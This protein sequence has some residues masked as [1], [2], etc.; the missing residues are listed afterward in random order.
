VQ[1]MATPPT[2]TP[3]PIGSIWTPEDLEDGALLCSKGFSIEQ[4]ERMILMRRRID[5]G[6]VNE[7]GVDVNHVE[8]M[9]WLVQH[10]KVSD[11]EV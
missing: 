6:E 9:R 5:R 8:F 11:W 2:A 3:S 4:A 7:A 10:G 1:A